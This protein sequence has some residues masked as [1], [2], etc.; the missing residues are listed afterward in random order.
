MLSDGED[1]PMRKVAYVIVRHVGGGGSKYMNLETAVAEYVGAEVDVVFE[2]L[3]LLRDVV[4]EVCDDN[5]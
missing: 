2:W 5:E 1:F 3:E 4:L